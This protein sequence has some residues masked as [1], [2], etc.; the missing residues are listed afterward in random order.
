MACMVFIEI[1]SIACVYDR[2]SLRYVTCIQMIRVWNSPQTIFRGHAY[3]N[4]MLPLCTITREK[5][6]ELDMC[7][8]VIDSIYT[9]NKFYRITKSNISHFKFFV[10]RSMVLLQIRTN[11]ARM[12]TQSFREFIICSFIC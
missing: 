6:R 7:I 9:F 12:S 10:I 11:S 5:E 3:A 1:C 8:Y 4:M 2:T